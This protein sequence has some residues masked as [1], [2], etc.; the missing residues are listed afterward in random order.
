M[1]RIILN[2]FILIILLT[3]AYSDDELSKTGCD[4]ETCGDRIDSC[5]QSGDC[6]CS[7]TSENLKMHNCTCCKTCIQCLGDLFSE[8]CSCVGKFLFVFV[9]EMLPRVI[10]LLV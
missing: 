7:M 4:A 9:L 10:I 5:T 3:N 6:N 8:C 1:A 2:A